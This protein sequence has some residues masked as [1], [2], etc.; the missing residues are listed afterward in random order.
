M[1]ASRSKKAARH[2]GAQ[3]GGSLGDFFLE[4]IHLYRVD[5]HNFIIYVGGDPVHD[6][7]REFEDGEPGV[8]YSMADRFA[9]NLTALTNIDSKRPILVELSSCGGDWEE[10]MKMFGAILHCPNPVTVIATKWARSMSSIIPLA[11][12][13]FIIRP[14]AKYMIHHGY[15][16]F[17]GTE[18]EAYTYFEEGLR[19]LEHMMRIYTARLKSQGAHRHKSEKTIRALL[20]E[21]VRR[22]I[23]VWFTADEAKQWGFADEVQEVST[24]IRR[25]MKVNVQR[26]KLMEAVLR[27]KPK[28]EIKI[29]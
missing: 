23:D 20:D 18:Q 19:A 16:A 15:T 24:D 2:E 3:S 11:A 22:K 29:S 1:S 7:N 27:K 12:D 9:A 8:D 4:D 10:G 13:K 25:A 21:K 6:G 26:R 14:P 17:E 28:V 5:R